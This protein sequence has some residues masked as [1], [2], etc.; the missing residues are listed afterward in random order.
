MRSAGNLVSLLSMIERTSMQ[1][2]IRGLQALPPITLEARVVGPTSDAAPFTAH[3]H[4]DSSSAAVLV[5]SG[6]GGATPRV[7]CRGI[8]IGGDDDYDST[9]GTE[10]SPVRVELNLSGGVTRHETPSS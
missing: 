5:R 1:A 9:D 7:S 6:N 4:V 3:V 8:V 2:M 10:F